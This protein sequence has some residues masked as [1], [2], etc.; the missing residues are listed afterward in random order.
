MSAIDV[1]THTWVVFDRDI[2]FTNQGAI[3]V[4]GWFGGHLHD[5]AY[6]KVNG[7]N[8]ELDNIRGFED[9]FEK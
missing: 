6:R 2:D 1:D 5:D 3:K 8:I 9:D 7:I 4:L